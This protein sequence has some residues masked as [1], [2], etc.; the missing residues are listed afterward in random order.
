MVKEVL[1]VFEVSNSQLSMQGG[2][3][4]SQPHTSSKA[5]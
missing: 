2:P 5:K 4:K 1:I 3:N